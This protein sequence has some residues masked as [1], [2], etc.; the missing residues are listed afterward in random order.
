MEYWLSA[1]P[2]K[3]DQKA[4]EIQQQETRLITQNI[5]GREN[6]LQIAIHINLCNGDR[7]CE[8]DHLV[9]YTDTKAYKSLALGKPAFEGF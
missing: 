5:V 1:R 4:R 7:D 3:E 6:D 8:I 2:V 9:L